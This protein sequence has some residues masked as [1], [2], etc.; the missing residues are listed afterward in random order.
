[1]FEK[2]FRALIC[3]MLIFSLSG[4]GIKDK[5][6]NYIEDNNAS[7]T[8]Q[9]REIMRCIKEKDKEGLKVL[10][11]DKIKNNADYDLDAQIDEMFGF[12]DYGCSGSWSYGSSGSEGKSWRE[13]RVSDWDMHPEIK[14]IRILYDDGKGGF[15]TKYYIIN[16]YWHI[17]CNED[18]SL[19][20][21]QYINVEYLNI[22]S[23]KIGEYVG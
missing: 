10:F 6:A 13:G 3:A 17:T 19:E 5:I 15:I 22:D 2:C 12:I 4:C 8:E 18:K 21:I 1:M 14:D 20:G 9:S 11:C 7:A 23:M 16:Y